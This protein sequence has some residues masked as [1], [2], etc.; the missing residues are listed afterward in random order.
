MGEHYSHCSRLE[1]EI[2][3]WGAEEEKIIPE[4]TLTR[5]GQT[6]GW[7]TEHCNSDCSVHILMFSSTVHVSWSADIDCAV[8]AESKLIC[9]K[10]TV[11]VGNDQQQWTQPAAHFTLAISR[12]TDK[13]EF[14]GLV[15]I[16]M[17]SGKVCFSAETWNLFI[18]TSIDCKTLKASSSF[19]AGIKQLF[20][21]KS[22]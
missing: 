21:A 10:W 17:W 8:S 20:V 14:Q 1:L 2:G 3:D 13:R 4:Q 18:K 12:H 9:S 22:C 15:S 19:F 6:L 11:D 5:G 7:M 16:V